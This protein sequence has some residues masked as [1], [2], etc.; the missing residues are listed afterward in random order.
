MTPKKTGPAESL[1]NAT[2]K[3]KEMTDLC[4]FDTCFRYDPSVSFYG[5]DLSL[6]LLRYLVWFGEKCR[7]FRLVWPDV[8][9]QVLPKLALAQVLTYI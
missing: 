8:Q 3:N 5:D 9:L 7:R 1:T 4:L 2:A 6:L